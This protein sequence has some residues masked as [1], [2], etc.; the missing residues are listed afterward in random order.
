ML[1]KHAGLRLVS[2]L[3]QLQAGCNLKATFTQSVRSS[4]P[5]AR[6]ARVTP[7]LQSDAGTLQV[8]Q[9]RRASEDP[10]GVGAT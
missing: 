1:G 8:Y 9:K 7:A 5:Q 3:S 4:M 2:F 6:N 10:G